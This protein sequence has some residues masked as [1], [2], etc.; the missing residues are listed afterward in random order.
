MEACISC[1]GMIDAATRQCSRCGRA[2][3]APEQER[4]GDG[5]RLIEIFRERRINLKDTRRTSPLRLLIYAAFAQTVIVA[6]LLLGGLKVSQPSV[7]SGVQDQA[8]GTFLV[9]T[10]VFIV[11]SAS[12]SA[13]YCLALAGAL[14]VRAAAGLPIVAATIITL[15]AVPISKLHAGTAIEPH[16]WLRW[17]QLGVLALL[18]AWALWR[19]ATRRWAGDVGAEH[20]SSGQRMHGAMLVGVLAVVV[21]YYV[22]EFVI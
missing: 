17:V 5:R 15:A 19:L 18:W 16:E 11:M 8:G 9:P 14:R 6:L 7:S 1:E 2:Q 4:H 20:Q 3:A 10:A 13:G 12:F 22:P 21:A